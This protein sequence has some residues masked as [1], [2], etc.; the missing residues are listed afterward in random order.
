[1]RLAYLRPAHGNG[2]SARTKVCHYDAPCTARHACELAQWRLWKPRHIGP[3]KEMVMRAGPWV[4]WRACRGGRRVRVLLLLL[5]PLRRARPRCYSH[6]GDPADV[7]TDVW[8]E[9]ADQ[10]WTCLTSSLGGS[11]RGRRTLWKGLETLQ[12]PPRSGKYGQECRRSV[13]DGALS[14][15]A[16]RE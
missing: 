14:L 9:G 8:F 15:P 10:L 5:C 12:E 6:P 16:Q 2:G 3:S 1:M 7:L 11:L 13:Y 4:S